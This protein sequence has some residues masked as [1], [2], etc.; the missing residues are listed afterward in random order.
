MK[1]YFNSKYFIIALVLAGIIALLHGWAHS[2][3]WQVWQV[4]TLVFISVIVAIYA[5]L[6]WV[7]K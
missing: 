5:A 6:L 2:M 3:M 1:L 4:G 7:K